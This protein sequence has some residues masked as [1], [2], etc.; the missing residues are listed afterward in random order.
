[1][2]REQLYFGLFADQAARVRKQD[3]TFELRE[4]HPGLVYARCAVVGRGQRLQRE[5]AG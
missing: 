3:G 4:C 1:M 2:P 5:Q